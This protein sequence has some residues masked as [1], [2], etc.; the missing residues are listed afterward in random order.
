MKLLA[1]TLAALGLEEVLRF[2]RAVLVVLTGLLAVF[3]NPP[4]AVAAHL[5]DTGNPHGGP[6]VPW[7]FNED[8]G[9]SPTGWSSHL[10]AQQIGKAAEIMPDSLS[11]DRFA[12]QWA[13]VESVRG[14]YDWK[15]ADEVYR[16][17]G[18]N[19][20]SPVMVLYNAPAWARDPAAT[21]PY[22]PRACAYPPLPAYDSDW[23]DFVEAAVARYP[24]VRAVEIWNEPNIALFWA[25][26]AQPQRYVELLAA[27]NDAVEAAGAPAPVITGGLAPTPT[28]ETGLSASKF[29]R[30]IYA[31]GCACDFEG[32]GAHPIV[33]HLP[34]LE[35]LWN[36]IGNLTTVRDEQGD[37]ETPLWITEVSVTTD[38]SAETGVSL[39]EQGDALIQL[40]RSIEGHDMRSFIIHRFR[41]V[42]EEGWFWSQ[43]GIV[44]EDLTP[45][46]AYCELGA[47][48]G[49]PCPDAT[50]PDTTAPETTI[51]RRPKDRTKS[52]RAR[53]E[54]IASDPGSTFECKLDAGPFTSCA[55]PLAD[56]V[57]RRKH[58]FEVRAIDPSGNADTSPAVDTW[59]VRKMKRG[60]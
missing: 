56:K 2:S 51:T 17:M 24:A 18:E 26:A 22:S 7:G 48:I 15:I 49:N 31:R 35:R 32:I 12:V 36:H 44:Y 6:N 40:Y 20:V 55:S 10:A 54:F 60:P 25:P 53:F 57:K 33:W 21:C 3:L 37:G 59:R 41:D 14:Q 46:P 5:T 38:Q 42:P 1:R 11:T 39:E 47:S 19:S 52:R 45:K 13:E 4:G 23:K 34:L 50:V 43:T 27:A 29:L 30:E 9:W 28:T 58:T 8:W 16:L